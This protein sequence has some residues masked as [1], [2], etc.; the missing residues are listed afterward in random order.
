[1]IGWWQKNDWMMTGD[2]ICFFP[3]LVVIGVWRG[4]QAIQE[5]ISS[6]TFKGKSDPAD[7]K[8]PG[9]A[10]EET[11]LR[12]QYGGGGGDLRAEQRLWYVWIM[13]PVS[14]KL[15]CQEI[16]FSPNPRGINYSTVKLIQPA[17]GCWLDM[18]RFVPRFHCFFSVI[19]QIT[20]CL[21]YGI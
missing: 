6:P 21:I 7:L 20:V 17:A 10:D 9:S 4:F 5:K 19:H 15:K 12:S 2:L 16:I 11:Q 8:Q 18:M 3:W 1:M 13:R 14:F